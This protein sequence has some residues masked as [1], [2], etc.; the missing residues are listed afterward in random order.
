MNN[1]QQV[2]QPLLSLPLKKSGM[3]KPLMLS[4]LPAMLAFSQPVF[5][6]TAGATD[7]ADTQVAIVGGTVPSDSNTLK[8]VTVDDYGTTPIEIMT[9]VLDFLIIDQGTDNMPTIID[10]FIIDVTNESYTGV[11]PLVT[12]PAIANPS[13][14]VYLLYN[15]TTESVVGSA[16]VYTEDT[17]ATAATA[18]KGKITFENIDPSALATI[19]DSVTHEFSLRAGFSSESKTGLA[20]FGYSILGYSATPSEAGIVT[21]A[22]STTIGSDQTS[23]VEQWVKVTANIPPVIN[24]LTINGTEEFGE[25]LSATVTASDADGD[26]GDITFSYLWTRGGCQGQNVSSNKDYITTV[27][28][29]GSELCVEVTATDEDG[30][31]SSS[32]FTSTGTINKLSTNVSIGNISVEYGPNKTISPS[33]SNPESVITAS[34]AGTAGCTSDSGTISYAN[35]GTCELT[36]TLVE[37]STSLGSSDT[38]DVTIT[39]APQTINFAPEELAQTV[40][41]DANLELGAISSVFTN[42]PGTPTGL[43][44]SLSS[45]TQ[46]ICTVSGQTVTALAAGNCELKASQ[47]GSNNFDQATPVTRTIKI[48]I[49][50]NPSIDGVLITPAPA[51]FGVEL[52]ATPTNYYDPEDHDSA[53]HTVAWTRSETNNCLASVAT[54]GTDVTYTPIEDDIGQYLCAT[55]TPVD[56]VGGKGVP[57]NTVIGPVQKA[58]FPVVD[59]EITD[60]EIVIGET[61]TVSYDGITS[62]NG[63][64]GLVENMTLS[65]NSSVCSSSSTF[66]NEVITVTGISR[67]TCF[68]RVEVEESSTHLGVSPSWA[69]IDVISATQNLIAHATATNIAFGDATTVSDSVGGGTVNFTSLD[70]TV[71]TV[72]DTSGVVTT[73]SVGDCP[74][75]VTK[76]ANEASGLLEATDTITI[77]IS[78]ASQT[79]LANA[80]ATT[81]TYDNRTTTVY[82]SIGGAV[83]FSSAGACQVGSNGVVTPTAVGPCIVT[84]I[85]AAVTTNGV[86]TTPEATS[87]VSI[88]ITKAAQSINFAAPANQ[89]YVPNGSF[90]APVTSSIGSTGVLNVDVDDSSTAG[91]TMSNGVVSYTGAGVCTLVATLAGTDTH[92]EAVAVYRNVFIAKSDQTITFVAPAEQTLPVDSTLSAQQLSASSGL[93]VGLSSST[94]SVCTVSNQTIT[95]TGAGAC[96]LTAEQ[97]G[98]DDYNAAVSISRTVYLNGTAP[99]SGTTDTGGGGSLSLNWLLGFSLLLLIARRRSQLTAIVHGGAK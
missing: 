38:A 35:V 94:P 9:E 55:I 99:V 52:S 46:T 13:D 73:Q 20:A 64:D 62:A 70:E 97:L 95:V 71:C 28:D 76:L 36:A 89:T 88:N 37:T 74:I 56:N 31:R 10:K 14:F 42:D 15:E 60:S 91:C 98:D 26:D 23:A 65:T 87:S 32:G 85:K 57:K 25:R 41:E 82:D 77:K 90:A 59:L 67:G 27:G 6:E 44:V 11:S 12:D 63:I 48:T 1:N 69:T 40:S 7:S 8:E 50:Q 47:N 84:V 39:K 24:S 22:G 66:F 29:I 72:G 92:V 45:S 5:A 83:T 43:S 18:G 2:R 68:I 17:P 93:D 78:E 4:V 30:D 19:P 58:P 54:I 51:V 81:I 80:T 3:V 34:D 86:I 79:V 61:T 21:S 96:T 53:A 49:N 75:K 16:G 33:P